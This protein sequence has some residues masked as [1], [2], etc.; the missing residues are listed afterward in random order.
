MEE[1]G[2][3]LPNDFLL[4]VSTASAQI[5]GGEVDSSWVDWYKQGKIKDGSDIRI[6]DDHYNRYVEDT[7]LLSKMHIEIY[8]FG[9]E[10]ARIMP[11]EN[12]I[13]LNV[14]KHYRDEI[15]LIKSKNIKPLL[16]IH[17]FSN[18]MWLEN[19]GAFLK[20]ENLH[21]YLDFV[22]VVI[23]NFGDLVS[24][25]ITINE[26][27]I[28]A[29][30]SYFF[31]MW[32]PSHNSLKEALTVLNNLTYCHIKAYE[33]IHKMRKE[34]GYND[35]MVSFANHV[36]VFEPK[37]KLNPWHVFSNYINEKF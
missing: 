8:R 25:Y 3:K 13:D 20:E 31:N 35:T 4:G 27:N 33:L 32:P 28:Y 17:H 22:K 23:D 6:S 26:P 19:K 16:T 18:P 9:I 34:K 10:W 7:E 5:E 14:I 29:F 2:F 1:K 21:Y 11:A 12:S 36:R 15:Q 37:C 24:D 30:N